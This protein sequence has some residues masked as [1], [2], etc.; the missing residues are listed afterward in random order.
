MTRLKSPAPRTARKKPIEQYEHR[1]FGRW[2]CEV[3]FS[4]SNLPDVVTRHSS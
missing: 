1:G 3:S 4:P 2:A